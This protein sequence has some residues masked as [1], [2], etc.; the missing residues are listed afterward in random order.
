MLWIKVVL[1]IKY[2]DKKSFSGRLSRFLASKID[3][4]HW[5]GGQGVKRKLYQIKKF[6]SQSCQKGDQAPAKAV[7][8]QHLG[9][10]AKW[11]S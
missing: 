2:S 1:L 5:I 10:P 8:L 6:C 7:V 9:K 3:S 4:E 11:V